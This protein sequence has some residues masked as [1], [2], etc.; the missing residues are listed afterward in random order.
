MITCDCGRGKYNDKL[1]DKCAYCEFGIEKVEE[2][3]VRSTRTAMRLA[4]ESGRG[5]KILAQGLWN[6]GQAK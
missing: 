6:T 5:R 4:R 2:S 1:T 3:V